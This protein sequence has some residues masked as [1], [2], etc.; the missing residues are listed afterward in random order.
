MKMLFSLPIETNSDLTT[1]GQSRS[2]TV[3]Y[4]VV[5]VSLDLSRNFKSNVLPRLEYRINR[6]RKTDYQYGKMD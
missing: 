4:F 3:Q 2:K 6:R 5:C 1:T